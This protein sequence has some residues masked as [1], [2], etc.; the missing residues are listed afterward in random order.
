MV[1][2]GVSIFGIFGII[3]DMAS[4]DLSKLCSG[5]I[6]TGSFINGA[7]EDWRIQLLKL[8]GKEVTP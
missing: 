5:P 7:R 3:M 1:G 4:G 8:D 2:A 6:Q